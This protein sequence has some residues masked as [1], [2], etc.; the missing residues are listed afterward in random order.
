MNFNSKETKHS[1][2]HLEKII[3][4]GLIALVC[5]APL[6]FAAV[7]TVSYSSL[8]VITGILLLLWLVNYFRGGRT[9]PVPEKKIWPVALPFFTVILWVTLQ[10][11]LPAPDLSLFT[12]ADN[13]LS[14]PA[15]SY[16]SI[17]PEKT[18]DNLLRLISY[19]VIFWLALQMNRSGKSA[20][21]M[22]KAIVV[23]DTLYGV[24][25][26]IMHMLNSPYAL[27]R[28][29]D[30]GSGPVSSTFINRN[31][32]ATYAGFC[33]IT[34]ASLW[35]SRVLSG[36]KE[37]HGRRML[38]VLL[39]NIVRRGFIIF[40]IV[41]II[42]VSLILTESRAGIFSSLCGF[43]A[44]IIAIAL[45]R[46]MRNF[47][48]LF[49]TLAG[50]ILFG[51]LATIIVTGGSAISRLAFFGQDIND[52]MQIYSASWKAL[53]DYGVLG[54][55]LGT[56]SDIFKSYQPETMYQLGRTLVVHH[57]IVGTM[58]ELGFPAFIILMLC[59]LAA[60]CIC[61]VGIKKRSSGYIYPAIGVGVITLA[62]IHSL[63]DFSME[64]P[65]VAI[66]YSAL[67]GTCIAQSWSTRE[68]SKASISN[69]FPSP[70]SQSFSHGT[71]IS[72]THLAFPQKTEGEIYR[73]ISI[74]SIA[75][76]TSA[77]LI[78]YGLVLFNQSSQRISI[79]KT[80]EA[81][82][83]GR[84][85]GH[86]K[87][88]ADIKT[89]AHLA[90][91]YPTAGILSDL[92]FME[93]IFAIDGQKPK[94]EYIQ[95][96]QAARLHLAI[97]LTKAPADPGNWAKISY[98]DNMLNADAAKVSR[99]LYLSAVTGPNIPFLVF[100]RLEITLSYWQSLNEEEQKLFKEQIRI[101][102]RN[103]PLKIVALSK[104]PEFQPIIV[105]A[106]KEGYEQSHNLLP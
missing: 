62:A 65:A 61:A 53:A 58:L 59:H 46:R 48:F 42:T 72:A 24:Y 2:N 41:I 33:L 67:I 45:T 91:E 6:P 80:I 100:P 14:A 10:T 101:A 60:F 4:A 35:L 25:G 104:N 11:L 20:G 44:F 66:T 70:E 99:E 12:L 105:K 38:K 87:L 26:L 37:K 76:I 49:L 86:E 81:F 51:L 52:R 88:L 56:F 75:L 79:T 50:I 47:R 8:A 54:S 1:T 34:A 18:V 68:E 102:W 97:S 22:L 31:H 96:M 83:L 7:E 40:N 28:I 94:E 74:V 78:I 57:N 55:G 77:F 39:N 69:G 64:I 16:I 23:S 93:L 95:E 3:N 9:L 43:L 13:T 32:Y 21:R 30:F 98:I 106:V 63:V 27:W 19:G 92:G 82:N 84:P 36:V 17:N 5:L 71:T 103:E 73:M 15:V 89:A 29:K 85:V 90:N